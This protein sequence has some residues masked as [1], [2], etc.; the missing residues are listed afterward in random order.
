MRR[1]LLDTNI[2]LAFVRGHESYTLIES[3]LSLNRDDT[4]TMIS[5]VTKAELLSLGKQLGW[6]NKKL[7][8]LNQLLEKLFI[9]DINNSDSELIEAYYTIDAFS[10]GKLSDKPLNDSARNMGKND[11]W[12]AATAFVAKAELITMDGDFDHLHNE[13]I[14]VHKY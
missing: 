7:S 12:I 1:F 14:T 13:F 11:L 5:V 6:G 8:K 9:I 3:E 10:Q 4:V 2:C